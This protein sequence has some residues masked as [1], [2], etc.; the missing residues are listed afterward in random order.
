[1]PG[2]EI[3][4]SELEAEL[5]A[6]SREEARE[7]ANRW[8]STSQESLYEGGDEYD[9]DVSNVAQ[10]GIPPQWDDSLDGYVIEYLHMATRFFND[11]TARHEVEAQE[12]EFLAFEWPDAPPEIRE[13][14]EA[15]FPTVFFQ[16]VEVDGI[17]ALRFFEDGQQDAEAYLEGHE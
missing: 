17:A 8:F 7:A 1:M 3:D 12:A 15:T 13:A 2:A 6:L 9:Y 11:G 16:S 5:Q 4:T 10:S 14:F